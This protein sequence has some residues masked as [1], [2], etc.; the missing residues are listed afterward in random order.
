M[1]IITYQK[2]THQVHVMM[3]GKAYPLGHAHQL[4]AYL[5]NNILG[6]GA[7][8]SRLNLS[9]REQ[10]GLVYTVE[11]TYTPLS[12]TG[13]WCIYFACDK[14]DKETCTQLVL[15]EL[16]QLREHPLTD[17]QLAAAKQQLHGQMA[18]SA[19]N[20]ENN[21]LSMA[22]HMLYF[23]TSPTWEETFAKIQQISAEELQ[24]VAQELFN[25]DEITL[26]EYV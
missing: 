26:L 14:E 24:K 21:V 10:R 4:A 19:E 16:Q 1:N 13:Y 6:G 5:L 23:G 8:N 7:L 9:L 18:I 20:R 22:K 12:D 2:H 17:K 3:G 11:S 15:A 25:E